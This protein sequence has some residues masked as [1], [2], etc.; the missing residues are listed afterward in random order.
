M[1]QQ[2]QL[3]T[4]DHDLLI[5]LDARMQSMTMEI[6]MANDNTSQRLAVVEAGK[7]DRKEFEDYKRTFSDEVKA[8]FL[9]R[10]ESSDEYRTA[11][12]IALEK[13]GKAVSEN[14]KRINFLESQRYIFMGVIIAAQIFVP[15]IIKY[16]FK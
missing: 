13:Y 6:R 4:N 15:I 2:T 8:S 7:L 1:D 10:K 3:S 14:S 12:D 11:T 9:N 16:L 5:R